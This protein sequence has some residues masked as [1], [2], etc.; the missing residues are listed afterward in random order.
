[1]HSPSLKLRFVQSLGTDTA[2]MGMSAS[3]PDRFFFGFRGKQLAVHAA[4][5]YAQNH[6][7]EV[8]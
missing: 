3:S 4:S 5:S 8:P 6:G 1:M 7:L 2:R